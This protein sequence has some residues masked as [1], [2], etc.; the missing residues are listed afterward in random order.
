MTGVQTR[1]SNFSRGMRRSSSSTTTTMN[2]SEF[3][4]F[5]LAL[6]ALQLNGMDIGTIYY[7]EEKDGYTSVSIPLQQKVGTVFLP[8]RFYS[9]PS[10]IPGESL[11][12]A[13][14]ESTD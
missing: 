7:R 14:D 6:D 1:P 12:N 10:I 2:S 4:Q 3:L 5:R 13:K 9:G 11:S 8:I